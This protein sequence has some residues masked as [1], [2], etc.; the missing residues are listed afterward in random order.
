MNRAFFEGE[1]PAWHARSFYA[2]LLTAAT[3]LCNAFGID[4]LAF[5]G[6]LGLGNGEHE[7]LN[8]IEMLM[9]LLFALWAWIE[10]RAPRYRL[11]WRR[12]VG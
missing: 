10:R 12:I 1:M 7:I 2:M 3:V 11:V 8:N 5:L 4:F 6:D 9:P